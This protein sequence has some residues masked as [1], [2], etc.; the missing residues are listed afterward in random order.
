M[1]MILA[2][3]AFSFSAAVHAAGCYQIFSS[4]NVLMWQGAQPPVPLDRPEIDDEVKK[5]VPDGHLI[6]VDDRSTPCLAV[7]DIPRKP[8]KASRQGEKPQPPQSGG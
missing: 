5:M 8:A 2:L 7:D 4:S 6:I 1:K 3:L